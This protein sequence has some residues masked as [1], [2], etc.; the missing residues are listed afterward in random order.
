MW[1]A[2]SKSMDL[3]EFLNP[4]NTLNIRLSPDLVSSLTG[5]ILCEKMTILYGQFLNDNWYN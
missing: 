3:C 1:F 5:T 4:S 2:I